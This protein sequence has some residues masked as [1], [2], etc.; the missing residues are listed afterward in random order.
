MIPGYHTGGLLYHDVCVAVEQL[1]Q[2]GYRCVALRPQ[3]GSL[4]PRL[5]GF[6]A[7]FLRLADAITKARVL[8]VLDIDAPFV[9]DSAELRG[10]SLVSADAAQRES[11]GAWIE[12]WIEL[13]PE[14]GCDLISF[15]SGAAESCGGVFDEQSL[16][17]LAGK[18]EHLLDAAHRRQV[19]L[20]LRPR[21]GDAIATVAQFE[22]LGQWL[23]DD[24]ELGLAADIGEMLIGGELPLVD[25][26]AR[27]LD[28]LA[29]VYLCDRR[30][31]Q[32]GDQ[33]IGQ[34][35]VALGRL[36]RFL[37]DHGFTGPAIV[38]IE[39]HCEWGLAAAREAISLFNTRP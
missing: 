27:N 38:R 4:N 16:E 30:A 28:A 32:A 5:P 31:G 29:C 9:Q 7:Q 39:G 17:H 20:A 22:R 12:Q 33:R 21:S 3:G 25:R 2:I 8:P 15:S 24:A 10:P 19:R 1:A 23:G 18:L 11:A 6:G 34:G 13:A 35:D 36:V 26:L 14:L 37:E